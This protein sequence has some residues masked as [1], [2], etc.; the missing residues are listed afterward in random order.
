MM[1]L[2]ILVLFIITT[3][4]DVSAQSV[5]ESPSV[6][7]MLS[8]NIYMLPGPILKGKIK[9]AK[10]IAGSLIKSDFDIILF[11][12][13]FSSK[14]RNILWNSL[15]ETYP[16]EIS[17]VTDSK[18]ISKINCGLW[19]ISKIPINLIREITFKESKGFD[20]FSN[21]GAKLFEGNYNGSSFQMILTHLQAGKHKKIRES[22]YNE[23][24]QLLI[25]P[26]KKDDVPLIMCGD[27]NI[28]KYDSVQYN[29]MLERMKISN[30][31]LLGLCQ[32]SHN[33][34]ENDF[35]NMKNQNQ[36]LFDYIFY[37]DDKMK[38]KNMNRSLK[39]MEGRW[40]RKHQDLSS[41]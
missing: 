35:R 31:N 24:T 18:G 11:Q 3:P 15:K 10:L 27:F 5:P 38:I 41:F 21:K 34:K 2:K 13:A 28:D 19:V 8:W 22:Q 1:K 40:S 7:K 4:I 36:Y 20:F 17:P 30:Y 16:Y 12:E 29:R 6:L 39:I 9:R 25:E 26:F 23:I 32:Y 37:Y 33:E 14:A